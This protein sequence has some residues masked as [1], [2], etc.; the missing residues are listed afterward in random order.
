VKLQIYKIQIITI[1][2]LQN[3]KVT[4]MALLFGAIFYYMDK[5]IN[6]YSSFQNKQE[7]QRCSF[8]GMDKN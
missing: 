6:R 8:T 7:R 3:D 5:L 1:C 4:T 2:N